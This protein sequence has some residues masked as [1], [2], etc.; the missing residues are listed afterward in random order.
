MLEDQSEFGDDVIVRTRDCE[1]GLATLRDDYENILSHLKVKNRQS[2]G[3]VF[4]ERIREVPESDIISTLAEHF[5]LLEGY[6]RKRSTGFSWK[7]FNTQIFM[8]PI[9]KMF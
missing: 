8:Q 4:K 1:A 6:M 9:C 3:E 7:R 5:D 2:D